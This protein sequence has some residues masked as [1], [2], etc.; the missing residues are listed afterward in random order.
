MLNIFEDVKS[1]PHEEFVLEISINKSNLENNY[2]ISD[3]NSEMILE[4]SEIIPNNRKYIVYQDQFNFLNKTYSKINL[5]NA[6]EI[7]YPYNN[8]CLENAIYSYNKKA[9]VVKKYFIN[10][11]L[12]EDESYAC[13]YALAFYTGDSSPGINRGASLSVRYG[14]KIT[15]KIKPNDSNAINVVM[16]YL[17]K[18]LSLIPFFWGEVIRA[19]EIDEKN[20]N[21]CL[22]VYNYGNVIAWTQF[23]SSTVGK[24]PATKFCAKRN[25]Y[26][27]IWSITGRLINNFSIYCLSD[28]NEV[29]FLPN[30]HFLVL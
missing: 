17:V 20:D 14:N 8:Y 2:E 28:E 16:Y 7:I 25:T 21:N 29:L 19:V 18:A 5:L 11:G 23:S 12:N 6:I 1:S 27:H 13:A 22:N 3:P 15:T 9:V 24:I 26:F 10:K 4:N 30:S